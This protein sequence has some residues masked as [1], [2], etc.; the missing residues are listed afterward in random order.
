MCSTDR[1]ECLLQVDLESSR[2][3]SKQRAQPRQL[4]PSN[5][6]HLTYTSGTTGRPKG[7]YSF[8]RACAGRT[9]SSVTPLGLN[10]HQT[11]GMLVPATTATGLMG[12]LASWSMHNPIR[13]LDTLLHE[14]LS[15]L[16]HRPEAWCST[17]D[18]HMPWPVSNL[19]C[20]FD[21]P[22]SSV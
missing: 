6:Q 1:G 17:D 7:V 14:G 2:T 15:E 19:T 21:L 11:H 5:L 8:V 22:W 16:P 9:R 20:L 10:S 4:L 18:N 3:S 12:E 13:G